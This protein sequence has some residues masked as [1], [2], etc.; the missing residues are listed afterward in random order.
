M[1]LNHSIQLKQNQ[2]QMVNTSKFKFIAKIVQAAVFVWINVLLTKTLK[3]KLLLGQLLKKKKQLVK[4]LMKNSL[5][6]YLITL[7]VKTLQK[8]SKALC[9]ENRY[10]NSP[11]LVLVVVKLLTLNWFLNCSVK[12]LSLLTQQV[13]LQSTQVHSR[14]FLTQLQKQAEV[15][16]G[17]THCSKT[18]LS[19]A[20]V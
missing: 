3:N 17:Q 16:L 8:L 12:M 13:V 5:T 20:L 6:N 15:R 2:M 11:A 18:T 4:L 1:L 9:L 7:W 19:S 10:S 14:Q